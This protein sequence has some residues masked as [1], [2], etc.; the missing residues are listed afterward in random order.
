MH[1]RNSF[2]AYPADPA[3]VGQVVD[4]A[5]ENVRTR[6]GTNDLVTWRH[7]DVCGHFVADQ[8]L[9]HIEK[10]AVLIADITRLNFN[11]LYEIGFAI[12]QSKPVFIVK[13]GALTVEDVPLSELGI[14]DTIGYSAYSNSE[15]LRS[16]SWSSTISRRLIFR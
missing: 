14:F 7:L 3:A 9:G 6:S 11:V 15:V 5:A 16:S 12:G 13:N 8:V 2:F 10:K 4:T 1:L